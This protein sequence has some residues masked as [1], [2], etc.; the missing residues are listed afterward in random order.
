MSWGYIKN[1]LNY[2]G[3]SSCTQCMNRIGAFDAKAFVSAGLRC[4]WLQSE[5]S[6]NMLQQ[7]LA[8]CPDFI[9]LARTGSNN[10][11]SRNPSTLCWICSCWC[12]LSHMD[13]TSPQRS[14]PM[15]IAGQSA[16][17]RSY[18]CLLVVKNP[19]KAIQSLLLM[20]QSHSRRGQKDIEDH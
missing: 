18:S 5:A 7:N 14:P 13:S 1:R 8:T 4:V 15:M 3:T 11:G 16:P 20:A 10:Y 6:C 9:A 17:I 2:S 19:L 12:L